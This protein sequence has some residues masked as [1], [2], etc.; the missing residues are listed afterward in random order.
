MNKGLILKAHITHALT[1]PLS[2]SY[3]IVLTR[4]LN[5]AVICLLKIEFITIG[6]DKQRFL[7]ALKANNG[8]HDEI[9]S[10][11]KNKFYF[12]TNK[13]IIQELPIEGKVEFQSFGICSYG[14]NE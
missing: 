4:R 9:A 13:G 2:Q 12:R 11:E 1:R 14:V 6:I 5:N 8:K 10:S 7:N 3:L